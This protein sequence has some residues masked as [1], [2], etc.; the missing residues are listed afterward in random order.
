MSSATQV[1]LPPKVELPQELLDALPAAVE[2]Q[3]EWKGMGGPLTPLLKR[4]IRHY[5]LKSIHC[6]G[7][8]DAIDVLERDYPGWRGYTITYPDGRVG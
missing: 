8:N 3:R 4:V 6:G 5:R 2:K 7:W 1:K